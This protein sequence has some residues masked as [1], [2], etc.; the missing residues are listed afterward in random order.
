[1]SAISNKKKQEK[2]EAL[3]LTES[4]ED[5]LRRK[6]AL[7]SRVVD[8]IPSEEPALTGLAAEKAMGALCHLPKSIHRL[9]SRYAE[10]H[11]LT[12][13]RFLFETVL[14]GLEQQGVITTEQ[15]MEALALPNDYGWKS[16]KQ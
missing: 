16:R 12:T 15:R 5:I 11:D 14:L 2:S 7:E 10:D 1:M 4:P 13:K 6:R 3:I 8:N 9:A